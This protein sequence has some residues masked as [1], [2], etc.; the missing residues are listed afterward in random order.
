MS[1]VDLLYLAR[2]YKEN[3]RTMLSK[4]HIMEPTKVNFIT[5]EKSQP[6]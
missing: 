6:A 3:T 2:V 4:H 5:N 1:R